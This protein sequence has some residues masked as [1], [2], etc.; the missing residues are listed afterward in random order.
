MEEAEMVEAEAMV[1]EEMEA[2]M[3]VEEM[4]ADM[5]AVEVANIKHLHGL[6][7]TFF[8]RFVAILYTPNTYFKEEAFLQ[9][10][11]DI[12]SNSVWK[13]LHCLV[14]NLNDIA[15]VCEILTL[16]KTSQASQSLYRRKISRN[17]GKLNHLT[18]HK[19]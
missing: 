6:I 17:F 2:D 18:Q 3:A 5:A 12:Y 19:P 4:E 11:D 14:I 7:G 1:A 8:Y 10:L 13:K 9:K 15:M 16:D